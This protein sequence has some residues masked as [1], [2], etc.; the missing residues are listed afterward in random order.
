M[1]DPNEN[2]SEAQKTGKELV[3]KMTPEQREG[4]AKELNFKSK[5]RS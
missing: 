3:D 1:S 4:A 2:K 5:R